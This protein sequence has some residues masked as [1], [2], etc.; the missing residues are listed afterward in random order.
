MQLVRFYI[1][2]EK[3]EKLWYLCNSMTDLRKI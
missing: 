2:R 1:S 3:R